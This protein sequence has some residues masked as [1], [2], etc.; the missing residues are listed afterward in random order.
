MI[1]EKS[2]NKWVDYILICLL[3]QVVVKFRIW[4]GIFTAKKLF[5]GIGNDCYRS[6]AFVV[7]LM[8]H[9]EERIA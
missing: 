6:A 1:H 3:S 9:N 2:L 7:T 4:R 8:K 5:I